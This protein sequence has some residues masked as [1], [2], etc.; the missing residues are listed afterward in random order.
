MLARLHGAGVGLLEIIE[1]DIVINIRLVSDRAM[2]SQSRNLMGAN[3]R[4]GYGRDEMPHLVRR[5]TLPYALSIISAKPL[6]VRWSA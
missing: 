6:T 3:C 1:F 4:A 5:S 2:V